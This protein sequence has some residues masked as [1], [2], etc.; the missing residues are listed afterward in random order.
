MAFNCGSPES[1]PFDP[2]MMSMLD[3]GKFFGLQGDHIPYQVSG[4][5]FL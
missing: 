2:E 3:A 1:L 4:A 5:K